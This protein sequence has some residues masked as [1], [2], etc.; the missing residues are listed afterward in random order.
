MAWLAVAIAFCVGA[1]GGFLVAWLL[2]RQSESERTAGLEAVK[3]EMKDSF[4]S[5]SLDTLSKL[6]EEFS[7]LASGTLAAE[8]ELGARDLDAR[9]GLIDKQLEQMNTQLTSVSE[10]VKTLEKDRE[11]KFGELS[12]R[13]TEASAQT[14]ALVE[15]TNTLS[16]ALANTAARGQWGERMAEDVLRVGGFIEGIN[17]AKQKQINGVGTRPD[18]TFFLPRELVLNMDVKF[19]LD[20]YLHCLGAE[21]DREIQEYSKK[22]LGD[23]KVRI[24]Q[25][26][27][28]DYINPEQN[29]VDCVLLFIPNEQVYSFIQQHDSTV[30]DYGIE[31]RVLLC[32]PVTLIAILSVIRQAVDNFAIAETSREM[33]GL[34]GQFRQQWGKFTSK[35]DELG[36][37]IKQTQGK[38]DELVGARSRQLEKPLEAIEDLRQRCALPQGDEPGLISSDEKLVVLPPVDIDTASEGETD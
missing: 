3:D 26:A 17:Y 14:G 25:V 13:L 8:K 10:L 24:K 1:A 37:K 11:K 27:G 15:V 32:S 12:S 16:K 22:F 23:V 21:N 19:P 7:K 34:F 36:T 5:L 31:N 20:N 18:Y 28:R 2:R 29:T 38:Y 9:K 6:T 33:L 35:M 30:I 4:G